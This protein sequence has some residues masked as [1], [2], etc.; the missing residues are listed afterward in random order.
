MP[1]LIGFELGMM[2]KCVLSDLSGDTWHF[3]RTPQEHVLVALEEIDKLAFLFRVRVGS[4][5]YSFGRASGFDFHGLGILVCHESPR[6]WGH[7][8]V[9]WH[10]GRHC[11]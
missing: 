4:N 10:R 6:R 3:C 9:E 11:P 5:L 8:W 2:F 7:L 1:C